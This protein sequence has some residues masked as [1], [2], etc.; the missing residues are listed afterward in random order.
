MTR[1]SC[2]VFGSATHAA[3]PT[4]GTSSPMPIPDALTIAANRV[5]TS[6]KINIGMA[7]DSASNPTRLLAGCTTRTPRAASARIA[8]SAAEEDLCLATFASSTKITTTHAF[9]HVR[10]TLPMARGGPCPLD[11]PLTPVLRV[12]LLPPQRNHSKQNARQCYSYSVNFALRIRRLGVRV[13]LGAHH[14]HPS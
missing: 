10:K 5:P 9:R 6:T 11:C 12:L 1:R 3:A 7:P 4:P 8:R 13:P 14:L 2:A